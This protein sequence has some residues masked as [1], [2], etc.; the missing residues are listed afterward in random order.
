MILEKLHI[1]AF[2]GLRNRDFT[3]APGVNLIEGENESG[4][5]SIA[6]FLKYLFYGLSGSAPKGELSEKIKSIPFEGGSIGGSLTVEKDGKRY[7]VER[8]SEPSRGGMRESCRIVDLQSGEFLTEDPGKF[9]FGLPEKLFTRSVYHAGGELAVSGAAMEEAMENLLFS[10]DEQLG[11]RKALKRLDEARVLLLHKNGKGGQLAALDEEEEKLRGR[12][13]EGESVRESIR[14]LESECGAL[15]KKLR[16]DSAALSLCERRIAYTDAA[17]RLGILKRR[18]NVEAA[19]QKARDEEKNYREE[20]GYEGFFP[21][22]EYEALLV[23]KESEYFDREKERAEEAKKLSE[24]RK[25]M[26]EKDTRSSAEGEALLEK[27]GGL[28]RRS[29]A[30]GVTGGIF[31][32]VLAAAGGLYAGQAVGSGMPVGGQLPGSVL[33][34]S[35]GGALLLCVLFFVLCAVTRKK[36]RRMLREWDGSVRDEETLRAVLEELREREKAQLRAGTAA[37]LQGA[38][39]R[40]AEEKTLRTLNEI[41]A[42][43]GK[44]GRRCE[45]A[46]KIPQLL[47]QVREVLGTAEALHGRTAQA[48]AVKRAEE[49]QGGALLPTALTAS[50]ADEEEKRLCALLASLSKESEDGAPVA[51]LS[52]GEYAALR[53]R[54]GFYKQT[55]EALREKLRDGETRLAGLRAG[56]EDPEVPR[57]ALEK[58]LREKKRLR[59]LHDAYKLAYEKMEEASSRLRERVAPLLSEEASDFFRA[60]TEG[61]YD[62]LLVDK[63]LEPRFLLQGETRENGYFSHGT[64]MLSYLGLRLAIVK[65]LFR[66]K[67][68]P[69]FFDESFACL[70]DRRFRAM[71][72]GLSALLEKGR[73][74]QIFLLT[75][76][77]RDGALCEEILGEKL[78]RQQ[79]PGRSSAVF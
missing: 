40:A 45:N 65:L 35:A 1:N 8:Q 6:A 61:R 9:F 31:L 74:E 34:A 52:H 7:R 28:R 76:Q 77:K 46:E 63:T 13:A 2:M 73:T 21:T 39:Y 22:R 10:A 43:A 53:K 64:R 19:L 14:T 62:A 56:M 30:L 59:Q 55:T 12:I 42:L 41:N 49:E 57:A 29:R 75:S 37:D 54:C 38:A 78:H 18:K 23:K 67:R 25:A 48:E 11:V 5:S 72:R 32:A 69:L 36:R 47:V 3:F 20:K 51:P 68:P 16:A 71:L 17:V 44:W 26:A 24:A 15:R 4:K 70:D 60:A 58:L 66:E 50:Q 33:L 79:L 27:A